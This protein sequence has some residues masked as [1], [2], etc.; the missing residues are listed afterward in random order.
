MKLKSSFALL[1]FALVAATQIYA[2]N[3]YVAYIQNAMCT[4]DKKTYITLELNRKLT[5]AQVGKFS[6]QPPETINCVNNYSAPGTVKVVGSNLSGDNIAYTVSYNIVL[7]QK[8]V[9]PHIRTIGKCTILMRKF[10]SNQGDYVYDHLLDPTNSSKC[11]T[12]IGFKN[13]KATFVLTHQ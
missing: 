7:K 13:N 6:T 3:Q 5:T 2:K 12:A 9:R 8:L 11:N 4:S 1:I 10:F